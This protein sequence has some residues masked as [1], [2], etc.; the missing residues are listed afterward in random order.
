[1]QPHL[2]FNLGRLISFALLGA[3]LGGIGSIF[4]L[5]LT[6]MSVFTMV[7]AIIMM[8]LALQMLGVRWAQRFR[9]TLPRSVTRHITS[10]SNFNG[11]LM[12]FV[13]GA[14]TFFLPCG[15]TITAQGLA[16]ASGNALQGGLIML[17]FALGT[18][19]IL[20]A[21]GL[22]SSTSLFTSSTKAVSLKV[23]GLVVLIFGL[24]SLN[25]QMNVLGLPSLNDLDLSGEARVQASDQ[26][27][28]PMRDGK[29]IISMDASAAG[30]EP[31]TFTVRVGTPVRWEITDTGTSGCTNAVIARDLFDGQI[32][33]TPGTTSVKEFTPTKEG[34]YKF[35]CWMGMVT[36]TI[37]VVGANDTS[38]ALQPD[39]TTEEQ[40]VSP[41]GCSCGCS[42]CRGKTP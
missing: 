6:A 24:Y 2:L 37:E 18:A 36:G 22:S 38:S 31:N 39:S 14:M 9:L 12:P 40:T 42:S 34:T 10:E 35:S 28:A 33:L 17:A 19:P 41:G 5:S 8:I 30:Y 29:Q 7:I 27:V 32:Q 15:F 25:A 11:R 13:L 20:L 26:N 23:A 16:L 3:V 21:I 4:R 1:V